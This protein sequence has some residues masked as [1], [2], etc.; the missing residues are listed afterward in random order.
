VTYNAIADVVSLSA[1][2]LLGTYHERMGAQNTAQVSAEKS[3]AYNANSW[4]RLVADTREVAYDNAALN[5][6]VDGVTTGFQLGHSFWQNRNANNT[7]SQAGL[8]VGYVT[9]K[10]DVTGDS[11]RGKNDATGSVDADTTSLMAYYTLAADS[12]AYLDAVVQYSWSQSDAQGPQS[13]LSLDSTG[14][15]GSL[16]AGV[17]VRFDSVTLEPQAQLVVYQDSFDDATDSGGYVMSQD[18]SSGVIF[19]VG[20]RLSPS[21]TSSN[22]KPWFAANL[23]VQNG[24]TGTGVRDLTNQ[25]GLSSE[26]DAKWADMSVGLSY[27]T[28]ADLSVYGHLKQSVAIGGGTNTTT[29]G[30]IGVQK[31]W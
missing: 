14:L 4:G 6:S 18:D 22:F 31:T 11:V 15:R 5:Q 26:K 10:M 28:S 9:G 20:A 8:A 1:N 30:A 16:E 19:R 23:N 17:P 29:S 21:D 25:F 12:G 24:S 27:Q 13:N 7:A 2:I 3:S